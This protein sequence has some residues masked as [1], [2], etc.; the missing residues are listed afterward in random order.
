MIEIIVWNALNAALNEENETPAVPVLMEAPEERT[1]TYVVIDKTGS[2]RIN[3]IDRA[4]V[5]VQSIAP[6][7]AEAASLNERVKAV[8]DQLPELSEKVFRAELN[9]DYNFTN[10]QTRERRY[11]A[12]YIITFKE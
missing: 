8:M 4:T 9:G 11:Q 5:A 1:A 6:T 10:T 3:R 12:V 2:S 7:L